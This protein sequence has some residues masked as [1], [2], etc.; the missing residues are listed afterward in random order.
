MVLFKYFRGL[1]SRSALVQSEPCPA[2][3]WKKYTINA[4]DLSWL[5]LYTCSICLVFS[6]NIV[7]FNSC[8]QQVTREKKYVTQWCNNLQCISSLTYLFLS[9]RGYKIHFLEKYKTTFSKPFREIL[10][11][12]NFRNILEF[13][14]PYILHHTSEEIFRKVSLEMI[15]RSSEVILYP[16]TR[17]VASTDVPCTYQKKDARH[18]YLQGKLYILHENIPISPPKNFYQYY[19]KNFFFT[20]WIPNLKTPRV[21]WLLINENV[22]IKDTGIYYIFKDAFL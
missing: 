7:V 21:S 5:G 1:C 18:I 16:L 11:I 9:K 4:K 2:H 8:S 19:Y 6:L 15:S 12:E 17:D 14:Y 10:K 3:Y 20:I 22:K 13:S